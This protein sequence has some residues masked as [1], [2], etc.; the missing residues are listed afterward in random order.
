MNAMAWI[1]TIGWVLAWA[2]IL[3]P[4]GLL[5]WRVWKGMRG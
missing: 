2:L 5:A 1:A 4:L 3:V